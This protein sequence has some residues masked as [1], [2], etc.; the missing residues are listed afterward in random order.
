[1]N[2]ETLLHLDGTHEIEPPDKISKELVAVV[3]YFN[4]CD[5]WLAEV[6]AMIDAWVKI[7]LAKK[8]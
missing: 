7:R 8:P 5:L 1:M 3:R 4:S 2:K 6:P